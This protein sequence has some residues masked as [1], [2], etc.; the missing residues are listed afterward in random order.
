MGSGAKQRLIFA[1]AVALVVQ[2]LFVVSYVGA[3]HSPRPHDVALGVVGSPA[4]PAA[5][6]KQFSLKT[7][8]YS[9]QA[10][11]L[12]AIDERKIVGAF[13]VS[14]TGSKLF[15]VPA[16]GPSLASALGAAF[17]A[18]ATV[19]HQKIEIVPVHPLPTRDPTGIVPFLLTMALVVGGYLSATMA[20]AFGGPATPRWRVAALAGVAVIGGLLTAT[21]AGPV[22]GAIPTSKFLVLW[23]LFI[24]V[25]AAVALATSALQSKLGPPGTLVVVVVFVIFGA[26]A[27]GG[28]V[29]ASFLPGFWRA[30]GPFLPAGAGTNAIR[31]TI[32]FDGNAITQALIVLTAY[33]VVGAAVT[34]TARRRSPPSAQQAEAEAAAAAAAAAAV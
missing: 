32:Y 16:A 19:F 4:V 29:P 1:L 26:P 21:I 5:V 14:P 6:Q 30:F 23:G 20:M 9:S 7:T 8:S 10:A 24:L 27:A 31:N 17:S 18:A 34:V 25:M 28:A 12:R 11:V 22:L 2:V 15:V 33:L 13:V 3:L